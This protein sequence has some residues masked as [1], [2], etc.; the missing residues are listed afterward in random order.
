MEDNN[1]L[2]WGGV[3]V[4]VFLGNC[5]YDSCIST[6]AERAGKEAKKEITTVGN[7][8]NEM[9]KSITELGY[10]LQKTIESTDAIGKQCAPG[11]YTGNVIGKPEPEK[12]YLING[13][14]AYLEIDNKPLQ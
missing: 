12:Y 8:V 3:F 4:A 13:Q 10:L 5:T 2:T 11:V 9:E 14:R 1:T 7:K 6:G